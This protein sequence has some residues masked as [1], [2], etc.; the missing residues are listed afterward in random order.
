MNNLLEVPTFSLMQLWGNLVEALHGKA[1]HGSE[2]EIYAYRFMIYNPLAHEH[3]DEKEL[4]R[5]AVRA[6]KNLIALCEMFAETS[7]AD[8]FINGTPLDTWPEDFVFDHR[9]KVQ[10]LAGAS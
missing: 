3:R 5:V 8:I 7:G 4:R 10:V 9:V 2:C 1:S 6:N